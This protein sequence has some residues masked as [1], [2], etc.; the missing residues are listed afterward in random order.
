VLF[1]NLTSLDLHGNPFKTLPEEILNL[2][3]LKS[4]KIS[5]CRQI[6]FPA[7]FDLIAQASIEDLD[8]SDCGISTLPKPLP[9]IRKLILAKNFFTKIPENI[10]K[11]L[12]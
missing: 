4:L 9:K 10:G 11:K 12:N 2:K 5:E 8:L 6:Q 3:R 1:E 7:F